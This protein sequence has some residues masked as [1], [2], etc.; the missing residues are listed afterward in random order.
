[1]KVGSI[2]QLDID[3]LKDESKDKPIEQILPSDFKSKGGFYLLREQVSVII[4]NHQ[5]KSI[6]F[7]NK[8]GAKGEVV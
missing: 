7:K 8:F 6:I 5:N 2:L 4:F 1:M 3:D